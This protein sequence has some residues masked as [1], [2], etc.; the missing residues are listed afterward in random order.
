[1]S[2]KKRVVAVVIS[3]GFFYF[4]SGKINVIL[5][6]GRGTGDGSR[7]EG[8]EGFR[9]V[10]ALEV[11]G[12]GTKGFDR[13]PSSHGGTGPRFFCPPQKRC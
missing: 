1:V 9:D 3:F 6:R 2:E 12:E 8:V 4:C 13:D 11:G 5:P 7:G 10:C